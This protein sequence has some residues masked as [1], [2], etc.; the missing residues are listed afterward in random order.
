MAILVIWDNRDKTAVR[1]EFESEWSWA[2]LE[3]A[4]VETDSFIASVSHAV[5]VIID[6]EGTRVPKDFMNAA[7][8]LLANPEPRP[9]EGNRIVVG[10]NGVIR[11]GYAAIRKAF[12]DR[13]NG[14]EI[15]FASDLDD[16]R[17]I[18]RSIRMSGNS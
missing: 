13:L 5:D 6:M 11:N 10:A 2:Q 4:V 17:A 8:N 12:G 16:A 18:L 3:G 1:M 7:K 14:R 9:N 15:L